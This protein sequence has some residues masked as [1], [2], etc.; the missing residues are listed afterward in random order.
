MEFKS[1][2]LTNKTYKNVALLNIEAYFL[3]RGCNQKVSGL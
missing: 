1:V 3:I 2:A